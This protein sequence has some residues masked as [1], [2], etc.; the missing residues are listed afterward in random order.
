M[1]L[2]HLAVAAES[3]EAGRDWV[4]EHLGV[5]LQPGGYHAHFGTHNLLLGL[6]DGLYLEVIAIDPGAE[7]PAYPRWFDLDR[8]EGAPRLNTWICQ[9]EDLADLV[10]RYPE[11]G[12]PVPLSRGDLRWQMAVPEDGVLPYDNMFPA[13]IEWQGNTH[14]SA[15]LAP[16]GARLERLVVCHPE[17]GALEAALA[18]V[19]DD[20]RV[21]FESGAA[22]L[23]A[24]FATPSGPRALG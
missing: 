6:E 2:D 12:R 18:P 23:R 22:G 7:A 14:P 9:V 1:K 11:A 10:A 8:F 5:R 24:E 20:A 4:E 17:A 15:R 3:L 19:L 21:V 16:S 13:V